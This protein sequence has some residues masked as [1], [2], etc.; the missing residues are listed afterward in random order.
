MAEN[1]LKDVYF[2]HK[3]HTRIQRLISS[4]DEVISED[5]YAK[6]FKSICMDTDA[7]AADIV[8]KS[9]SF[10]W[11]KLPQKDSNSYFWGVLPYDRA[12]FFSAQEPA[13]VVAIG[14]RGHIGA[15]ALNMHKNGLDIES[16]PI[17]IDDPLPNVTGQLK[18]G[19]VGHKSC[20]I[21]GK[22]SNPY[23]L[24]SAISSLWVNDTQLGSPK[25]QYDKVGNGRQMGRSQI[26]KTWPIDDS[27]RI[28]FAYDYGSEQNTFEITYSGTVN[29]ED[30]VTSYTM[31]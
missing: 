5:Y 31:P 4:N 29:A 12:A 11:Q 16:A 26:V 10:R 13:F 25:W 20:A 21:I 17:K 3:Q 28:H 30:D 23:E 1:E 15:E 8:S 18:H 19:T 7:S 6:S 27:T 2:S 14:Y 24:E 22:D 9:Q